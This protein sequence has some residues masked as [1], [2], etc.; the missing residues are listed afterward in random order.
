[1]VQNISSSGLAVS[2]F[3]WCRCRCRSCSRSLVI[4]TSRNP[5]L[6]G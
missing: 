6:K 1:M 5:A 2:G 4:A 3:D